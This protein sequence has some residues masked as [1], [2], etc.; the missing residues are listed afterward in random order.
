MGTSRDAAGGL[1]EDK[2]KSHVRPRS[3]GG[4]RRAGA[5]RSRGIGVLPSPSQGLGAE[6]AFCE[7]QSLC[8][9]L[10][11]KSWPGARPR[12]VLVP[13]RPARPCSHG[14]D[15]STH[16]SPRMPM[17]P[18]LP[19]R[20]EKCLERRCHPLRREALQVPLFYYQAQPHLKKMA[21]RAMSPV[22]SD[23]QLARGMRW[24]INGES[25][26]CGR[27]KR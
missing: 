17:A 5:S 22:P 2:R 26:A 11:P 14:T 18:R 19:P 15:T 4:G 16:P 21:L 25:G 3:R 7:R 6:G 1:G 8:C 23:A 20:Q 24:K 9:F 12:W 10:V 13:Q 27:L